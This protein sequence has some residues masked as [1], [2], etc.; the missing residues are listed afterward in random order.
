MRKSLRFLGAFALLYVASSHAAETSVVSIDPAAKLGNAGSSDPQLSPNGRYLYYETRA[1]NVTGEDDGKKSDVV[2]FDRKKGTTELLSKAHDGSAITSDCYFSGGSDNGRYV[3]FL[4]NGSGIA[5]GVSSLDR[6]GYVRDRITGKV[7]IAT[8]NQAGVPQNGYVFHF[9]M[10]R[11]GRY[12]LFATNASNMDG[13]P[14]TNTYQ[15]FLRDLKLGITERISVRFDGNV[16]NGD[17]YSPEISDDGRYV[18]FS[19]EAPDLIPVDT[20]GAYDVFVRD[21]KKATTTLA[22]YGETGIIDEGSHAF[23]IS[24]DGRYIAFTSTGVVVDGKSTYYGT[25]VLDRKK[26][27]VKAAHVNSQ[28]SILGGCDTYGVA[29]SD[30]GRFVS[31]S[32]YY[33]LEPTDPAN[34][35][36]D[37]VLIDR[38]KDTAQRVALDFTGGDPNAE[39]VRATLDK[40]AKFI[41]FDSE[42]SDLLATPT[43]GRQVFLVER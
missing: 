37:V 8:V 15:V 29:I 24:R 1:D 31:F 3:G 40:R 32:T 21:R 5:E 20:N 35:G 25:Y 39:S 23:A 13:M 42:A 17:C 43:S 36:R 30:N 6:Q 12:A 33:K 38:K 26:Q 11:T 10:N 27:L 14:W 7:T 34:T 19:S 18:F 4:A 28:G 41:A 9:R 2:L 22:V 16:P